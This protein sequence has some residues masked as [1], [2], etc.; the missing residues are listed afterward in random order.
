MGVFG[1]VLASI[2]ASSCGTEGGQVAEG[3][4][5]ALL[6][7]EVTLSMV[8]FA[9]VENK[10]MFGHELFLEEIEKSFD[11]RLKI[12]FKGGEEAI[13]P[14]EQPDAVRNGVVDI[15]FTGSTYPEGVV[16]VAPAMEGSL[17]TP[18]EEREQG[19]FEMWQDTYRE[20]LNSVYLGRFLVNRLQ[21]LY[22]AYEISGLEDF[23]G[24]TF[25]ASPAQEPL[26]KKLG[27]S[28]VTMPPGEIFTSLER[29]VVDG[30]GWPSVG[31]VD[32]GLAPHTKYR[33]DPGFQSGAGIMLV[34]ADAF[35]RLPEAAQKELL[36]IGE[37]VETQVAEQMQQLAEEET[38]QIQDEFGVKVL[39]LEGDEAQKYQ[40]LAY[41]GLWEKVLKAAPEDGK[42]FH[43]ATY[44]GK[45]VAPPLQEK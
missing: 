34:N 40:Q 22:A 12:D 45:P 19:A 3:K 11:G 6:G 25:R 10:H 4:G 26:L 9:S 36:A 17:L 21:H 42:K 14:F 5:D 15:V 16:P 28:A 27:A 39:T 13:D 30:Y 44:K 8:T 7:E 18:A 37:R 29:G 23:K 41:D 32:L 31:M 38:K 33:V 24:K 1:A 2:A 35:D 20:Q 43:E